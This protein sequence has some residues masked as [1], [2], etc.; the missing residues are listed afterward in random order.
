M[1]I[2]HIATRADWVAAETAGR[3]EVSSRVRTL[4]EEGF[5]HAST[6]RQADGVLERYYADLPPAELR[7]LVIDVDALERAGSLVQWDPVPG[8]DA[9]FPHIY[10]P[11][12]PAA[13]VGVLEIG[14]SPGAATLPDLTGWNVTA[15]RP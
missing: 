10:G 15:E 12:V 14:G 5:I 11:I 13:V 9:P 1:R 7:L 4:A 2:L 8:A 6:S 3:Y